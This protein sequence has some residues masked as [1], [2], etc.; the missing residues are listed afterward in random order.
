MWMLICLGLSLLI[1]IAMAMNPNDPPRPP[2][3]HK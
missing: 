1:I 2:R 3:D